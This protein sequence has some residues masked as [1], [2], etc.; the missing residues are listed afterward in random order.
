LLLCVGVDADYALREACG[1]ELDC[2]VAEAA[3][4]AEDGDPL[5]G[6]GAAFAQGGVDGD[7]CCGEEKSCCQRFLRFDDGGLE[8]SGVVCLPAHSWGAAS[9]ESRPSGMGVT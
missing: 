5:P 4:G 7:A 9:T 2:D 3:A 6:L 8:M 1:G